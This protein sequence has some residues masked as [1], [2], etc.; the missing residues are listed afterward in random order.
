MQIAFVDHLAMNVRDL[1]RSLAFYHEVLGMDVERLEEYRAGKCGF[2]SLR[3]NRD[4]VIDLMQLPA[5][6]KPEMQTL[7]HFAFRLGSGDLAEVRQRIVGH[8]VEI[9]EEAKP[10]WGARGNGPSMKVLDPDG[11]IVEIKAVA[12]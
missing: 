7:N 10:R 4:T 12:D 5:L 3:V 1:D 9:V 6:G 11:N 2:P 8:E